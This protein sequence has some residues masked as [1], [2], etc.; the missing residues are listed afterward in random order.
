MGLDIPI[1]HL[2]HFVSV[3]DDEAC[4]RVKCVAPKPYFLFVGRLEK[5]KGLQT[6]IPVFRRYR[7][8]RLLVVGS[9]S[10][11]DYLR[12]S[13]KGAANIEFLGYKED[14]E[15]KTLYLQATA[16]IV[17]SVCY[18]VFSLVTLEAFGRKV[19]VIARDTGGLPETVRESGAGFVYSTE[20]EL[21][22]AMDQLLQDT[23]ERNRLGLLGYRAYQDRW[24]ANTHLDRYLALIDE[25]AVKRGRPLDE[26]AA[27]QG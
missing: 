3:A 15:L 18:E 11:E 9:G 19:P 14:S 7:K 23:C 26:T 2:P 10:D 21:V 1:V 24:T 20:E 27:T 25:I 12:T 8:A 6:L 16:V 4:G 22:T 5:V 17:P 13:A